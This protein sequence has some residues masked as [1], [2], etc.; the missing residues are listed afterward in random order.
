MPYVSLDPGADG[1]DPIDHVAAHMLGGPVARAY[2]VMPIRLEDGRLLLALADPEEREALHVARELTRHEIVP[3]LA[4]PGG[5]ERAQRRVYGPRTAP[6]PP[7]PGAPAAPRVL[8]EPSEAERRR[9]E[10][11]ARHAGLEFVSLEPGPGGAPVDPGAAR[12]LSERVCRSFR[13]LPIAAE[14]SRL[15]VAVDDPQDD[16]PPRVVYALT[17]DI[18]RVVVTTPAGLERAIAR[19]FGP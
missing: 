13:V 5:I 17:G 1:Q 15:T 11:L 10:L 8:P 16:V 6:S 18:P 4:S 9:Y 12:S 14:R 7:E 19:A 2:G 3:V